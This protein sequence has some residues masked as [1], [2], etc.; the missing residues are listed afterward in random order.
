[1]VVPATPLDPRVALPP[2]DR[3]A[4]SCG[5]VHMGVGDFHRAHQADY[6]DA[7]MQLGVGDEW[8]VCE[9]GFQP[10]DL[11]LRDA[12]RAQDLEYTLVGKAADGRLAPRVIGSVCD[13]LVIPGDSAAL[14]RRLEDP[15]TRIVSLT[16]GE[17]GY[18]LDGATGEFRADDPD[19]VADLEAGHPQTVWGFI[20]ASLARRRQAGVPPFTVMSCDDMPGNGRAARTATVGFARALDPVLA[21]WIDANVAFPGS[22]LERLIVSVGDAERSWVAD[23]L[24]VADACPVIAEPSAGWVLQDTFSAG[25]PPL[26]Q[27][28]VTLANDVEPYEQTKLYLVDATRQAAAYLGALLGHGFMHEAVADRLVDGF[29]R[30]YLATEARAALPAIDGI[31]PAPYTKT[32]LKR[33]AN[34][35]MPDPVARQAATASSAIPRS[36]LPVVRHA[37]ADGQRPRYGAA[38]VAVW[39]VYL[40]QAKAGE[41]DWGLPTD[42]LADD[43]ASRAA[44]WRTVPLDFLCHTGVFGTLSGE[45][46]FVEAYEEALNLLADGGPKRLVNGLAGR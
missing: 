37:L 28:G 2:Y 7:L 46:V 9:V 11:V 19:V 12:L 5:I 20:V 6:L 14:L 45:L 3:E 21:D 31:D 13:Y 40:A 29:L 25:R 42:P 36:V 41:A 15:A 27:V 18:L 17:D 34:P 35:A 30:T 23:T 43:L 4:V 38:I 44:H 10:E 26:D 24:G 1:M 33:L 39:A 32:V 8:G 16:I 22:V